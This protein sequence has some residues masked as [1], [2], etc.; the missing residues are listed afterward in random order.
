MR[1]IVGTREKGEI[2]VRDRFYATM[3][4]KEATDAYVHLVYIHL[5]QNKRASNMFQVW[6]L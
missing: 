3:E 5:A 4:Y 6:Q 1:N 2:P